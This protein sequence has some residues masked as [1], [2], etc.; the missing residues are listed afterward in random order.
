MYPILKYL[1]TLF[2]TNRTNHYSFIYRMP[3]KQTPVFCDLSVRHISHIFDQQFLG[4]SGS[5]SVEVL[6]LRNPEQ[7][8]L[9]YKFI[10]II[11]ETHSRKKEHFNLKSYLKLTLSSGRL[12]MKVSFTKTCGNVRLFVSL[13]R[14]IKVILAAWESSSTA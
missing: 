12:P 13:C 6:L 14:S 11:T 10:G 5:V 1:K 8:W 2:Y 3:L 4:K 9:I 7:M